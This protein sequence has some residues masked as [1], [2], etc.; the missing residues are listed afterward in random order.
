MRKRILIV[1]LIVCM[2]LALTPATHA[3]ERE[4]TILLYLCGTD[5]ESDGGQASLDIKEIMQSG[6]GGSPDIDFVIA[7]G[8]S[9]EW[10]R[11]NIS[12][13]TIQYYHIGSGRP[14]L[15]R[16]AGAYSMGSPEALSDFIR[17]GMDNYPA[18][19]YALILWDHGGGPVYGM[20][21][22][23]TSYGDSLMLDELNKALTD[24]L[25][26][27]RLDIIAYDACLMNCVDSAIFSAG[28]AD[29]MVSSQELVNGTGFD[30]DVWL[31]QLITNPRM[32]SADLAIAIATSYVD[33]NSRLSYQSTA[34]MSVIDLNRAADLHMAVDRF[35]TALS[36]LLD[37]NLA[38]IV[39]LRSGMSSFGEFSDSDASDLVDIMTM[40]DTYSAL[41]PYECA[42][43]KQAAT[44]AILYNATT[45]DL[46]GQA[47]GLSYFLPYTTVRYEARSILSWY[48]AQEGGYAGAVCALTNAVRNGGDGY[49]MQASS[50]TPDNFYTYTQEDGYSGSFVQIWNGMYGDTLPVDQAADSTQGTIWS[51]LNTAVEV[52]SD[53]A[54]EG[55]TGSSNASSSDDFE[56]ALPQIWSGMAGQATATPEPPFGASP[57]PTPQPEPFGDIWAVQATPTPEQAPSALS[58]IWSGFVSTTGEYYGTEENNDNIQTG[59]SESVSPEDVV[60]AASNYFAESD[61]TS[62]SIY[63]MQLTRDDLDHL[64]TASGVLALDI[65][66]STYRLGNIGETLIDWSTG[67]IYSMFDG[68]WPTL[69]GQLVCAERLY[70]NEDGS[71][72]LIIPAQI[73][74]L[75]MYLLLN[76][77]NDGNTV[78]LGATQGYD[79]NGYAIRGYIPLEEGTTVAPVLT[80][81][82]SDGGE[83]QHV[84]NPIVVTDEGLSFE[85][86]PLP[87][88]HYSYCFGL[89]D[90]SGTVQYT[91]A[92]ELAR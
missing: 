54:P 87:A 29:Y 70:R 58:G 50:Q 19:R 78:I 26:G 53:Q 4:F 79:E 51:G 74:G 37:N 59:V 5:L 25:R 21:T 61:E 36:A 57:T 92:I 1:S 84:L 17:F 40:C 10:Q 81:L 60:A 49:T 55:D 22:D 9:H 66:D 39:R 7:T 30:Y 15:L 13:D 8:G 91:Q 16:D 48:D 56:A 63:T 68:S 62:Q 14:E 6:V 32:S 11:Y 43:L 35:G 20:C 77:D 34:T 90:L 85:W 83:I 67:M 52:W 44:Q 18:R 24:G 45:S 38:T 86:Q 42:Y 88:G 80:E 76:M 73:N 69:N 31:R 41:L 23:E 2:L 33:E 71:Q 3:A 46:A 82:R 75:N 27:Q 89:V 12:S 64:V 47:S 28:F 72:R 65:G